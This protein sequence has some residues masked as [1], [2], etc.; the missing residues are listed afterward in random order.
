MKKKKLLSLL[1]AA[2]MLLGLAA[3]G[4]KQTGTDDDIRDKTSP[5]VS[6][7][8][9]GRHEGEDSGDGSQ[10][11]QKSPKPSESI[12]EDP[13]ELAVY[14]LMN[15]APTEWKLGQLFI[16]ITNGATLAEPFDYQ[17]GGI[18]IQRERYGLDGYLPG[19]KEIA[20]DEFEGYRNGP[21]WPVAIGL[22]YMFDEN[23]NV[24]ER[25]ERIKNLGYDFNII[26]V[27]DES[28][29]ACSAMAEHTAPHLMPIIGRWTGQLDVVKYALT[30]NSYPAIL[31]NNDAMTPESLP[32]AISSTACE[33]LRAQAGDNTVLIVDK[34][35]QGH[36]AGYDK[37]QSIS[38]QV[39]LAG[40]DMIITKDF[41]EMY[42][43]ILNA[44]DSG[45]ID[46]QRIDDSCRRVLL[47]KYNN[48]LISD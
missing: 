46:P 16:G 12:P 18:L 13:A 43:E 3:C 6:D 38:V 1:L 45:V 37:E 30:S 26:D 9:Q 34:L 10:D 5:G 2:I 14:N 28:P 22:E 35:D 15:G 20:E 32:F 48:G 21:V 25:S 44:V 11:A 7:E 47:W 24:D 23:A 19:W 31:I 41:G 39:I 36:F 33:T 29:E 27:M 42:R 8:E 17:L 40:Y 4:V